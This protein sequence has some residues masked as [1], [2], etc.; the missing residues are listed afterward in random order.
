MKTV[1]LEDIGKYESFPDDMSPEEIS[2][3]IE[4]DILPRYGVGK[5]PET[6]FLG[7]IKE[8]GKAALDAIPRG[9]ASVARGAASLDDLLFKEQ[10]KT[11]GINYVESPSAYGARELKKSYDQSSFAQAMAANPGYEDS[12]YRKTGSM[13]GGAVPY[14]AAG[15]VGGAPAL[16]ALGAL[17]GAGTQGEMVDEARQQG[18]SI[19]GGD[20]NLATALGGGIGALAS[21][22]MLRLT[23]PIQRSLQGVIGQGVASQTGRTAAEAANKGVAQFL[24]SML[25]QSGL[26]GGTGALQQAANN[27]VERGIINPDRNVLDNVMDSAVTGA[28]GGAILDATV[29]HVGR[30]AEEAVSKPKKATKLEEQKARP[31]ILPGEQT[32]D[33]ASSL[34]PEVKYEP[35]PVVEPPAPPQPLEE[36]G[37][38]NLNAK[39]LAEAIAMREQKARNQAA[40]EE[41]QKMQA[42]IAAKVLEKPVAP[43]EPILP[44]PTLSAPVPVP[45]GADKGLAK[46][47]P[48]QQKD[49]LAMRA[50]A[51]KNQAKPMYSLGDPVSPE[52][53]PLP[54]QGLSGEKDSAQPLDQ[55]KNIGKQ[56]V[57]QPQSTAEWQAANQHLGERA[58]G[59]LEKMNLPDVGLRLSET[60]KD[61]NGQPKERAT[62]SFEQARN[63]LTISRAA[64][65]TPQSL[66]EVLN[67]EAQ[68]AVEKF[69]LATPKE[70][71]A[72]NKE[73]KTLGL[74]D[75]VKSDPYYST[76]SPDQQMAE[77]RAKYVAGVVAKEFDPN[78]STRSYV[79]KSKNLLRRIYNGAKGEGFFTA[80]DYANRLREGEIGTRNRP[81]G[82]EVPNGNQQGINAA[83]GRT[84][85]TQDDQQAVSA[86]VPEAVATAGDQGIR[87]ERTPADIQPQ[88]L[89]QVGGGSRASE[90]A[91]ESPVQSVQR[92]LEDSQSEKALGT[93][94]GDQPAPTISDN[95]TVYSVAQ[96]NSLTPNARH[97]LGFVDEAIGTGPRRDISTLRQLSGLPPEQ[98]DAAFHE[99]RRADAIQSHRG[100][101]SVEY[102]RGRGLSIDEGNYVHDPV[103][104]RPFLTATKTDD[105]PQ[106]A[107]APQKPKTTFTPYAHP[108]DLMEGVFPTKAA[109]K[110]LLGRM[111]DA[112]KNFS[113]NRIREHVSD[114]AIQSS[115]TDNLTGH[116]MAKD[117]A[118]YAT[119]SANRS[120][121]LLPSALQHGAPVYEE[122]GFRVRPEA[123]NQGLLPFLQKVDAKGLLEPFVHYMTALRGYSL[124]EQGRENFLKP[125]Q[126]AKGKALAVKHPELTEF[127]KE[128]K[129]I[130]DPWVDFLRQTGNI[131]P[132]MAEKWK[133]NPYIPFFRMV[134]EEQVNQPKIRNA[135]GGV[136]ALKTLKGG[137][138]PIA[139]PIQGLVHNYAAMLDIGMQN[140]AANRNIRN[141][142]E[143]GWAVPAKEGDRTAVTHYVNGEKVRTTVLDPWSYN[144]LTRMD[145][146]PG[147]VMQ[148][149]GQ[150]SHVLRNAVTRSPAFMVKNILRDSIETSF[151]G[152]F[153]LIP[154][155]SAAD[156]VIQAYQHSPNYQ[157]LEKAGVTG[158]S[159]MIDPGRG[160]AEK[161]RRVI[162]QNDHSTSDKILN[163]WDKFG[164]LTEKSEAANRL[165]IYEDVLKR[166]GDKTQAE[167]E[168]LDTMN[169]SK[170]GAGEII[171]ILT[172][173]VPFM[174]ARIQGLDMITKTLG[175]TAYGGGERG[176]AHQNAALMR[177]GVMALSS[178]LYA[179]AISGYKFW[180]NAAPEER[181][182]YWFIPT[183][184]TGDSAPIRI[185]APFELGALFKMLP[186]RL[187]SNMVTG[188][189]DNQA[190]TGAISRAVMNNL[191]EVPIPQAVKPLAEN[192]V[193]KSF[194]R[195][196]EIENSQMQGLLPE[197][198]WDDYTSMVAREA[199]KATGQSPLMI[200]NI[201]K[202]Y[203]GTMGVFTLSLMDRILRPAEQGARP[204]DHIW[205][206]PGI[207][208][209]FQRPDGAGKI[210][211]FYEF[212]RK[213]DEVTASLKKAQASGNAEKTRQ[214]MTE[215]RPQM[216]AK[217]ATD[218]LGNSLRDLRKAR[219]Q[220]TNSSQFS[221]EQKK[222]LLDTFRA[223]EIEVAKQLD[224]VKARL[225]K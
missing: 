105:G 133:A 122:G 200:D 145:A 57:P 137:T 85:A 169:F 165:K 117:S 99:L 38:A 162:R 45:E 209:F 158:G 54:N 129:K 61:Q 168:S 214:I 210:L 53:S 207:G 174:N 87:G 98:F 223:R 182:N 81:N 203:T 134:G 222:Q 88:V 213:V 80:E 26:G 36:P 100:D 31:A 217:A 131:S 86:K 27:L 95:R 37:L 139:D 15:A 160:A 201:L 30:K 72:V 16:L 55:S 8:F 62:G 50:Q 161:I 96:P 70:L 211:Q 110:P 123:H 136:K 73:A 4:N 187:W 124:G 128:F 66:A 163:L 121:A 58:Q 147:A 159:V 108:E 151:K 22:P 1:Y 33:M 101:A 9:A 56:E 3:R 82:I 60:I 205:N 24:A 191:A 114:S 212:D 84:P 89:R 94:T 120:M 167:W 208:T 206:T 218:S 219:V 20:E 196:R 12:L 7:G 34:Y 180:E 144:M 25:V 130:N 91:P 192:Y 118:Y 14:M 41:R 49:V 18:R 90:L 76:L 176:K 92:A 21:L 83:A 197:D 107:M 116:T 204:A 75:E 28:L 183:D 29:G 193:N 126:I 19:S 224:A 179:Q 127:V 23:N 148:F 74:L 43:P 156:G 157:A 47:T 132:G 68:H 52:S 216:M 115:V 63:L 178:V 150:F 104:G 17:Q 97:L 13:V 93:R 171:K 215:N 220:I 142:K 202:G 35:A 154:F 77:A 46:L 152:D 106:F 39:Q 194:F 190:L 6:G 184:A 181:D 113:P 166:T 109:E 185:P 149:L 172:P 141:L 177:A 5:K 67:H 111:V 71:T 65:E 59:L 103:S 42:E 143:L 146:P 175:G 198:R 199:G 155:V 164:E 170:R 79:N 188:K 51:A 186:E 102:L 48:Q 140:V 225:P 112:V 125:E 78:N 138:E 173:L 69:T 135:T 2:R 153:H 221:A 195:G 119:T 189:D 11:P 44:E 32:L 64:A 10:P 40:L